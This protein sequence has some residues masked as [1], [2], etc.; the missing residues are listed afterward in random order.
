MRLMSG[1]TIGHS[2]PNAQSEG[3]KGRLIPRLFAARPGVGVFL[4]WAGRGRLPECDVT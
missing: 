1:S 4:V 2:P 3:L